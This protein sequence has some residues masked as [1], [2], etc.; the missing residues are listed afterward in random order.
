MATLVLPLVTR[1]STHALPKPEALNATLER[2]RSRGGSESIAHPPETI[3]VLLSVFMARP[4]CCMG[5]GG[6][7]GS[8]TRGHL[9]P[10]QV[11]CDCPRH[12]S[13]G[14][15]TDCLVIRDMCQECTNTKYIVQ[16][17]VSTLLHHTN[18]VVRERASGRKRRIAPPDRSRRVSAPSHNDETSPIFGRQRGQRNHVPR[19]GTT[20]SAST[21]LGP[22]LTRCLRSWEACTTILPRLYC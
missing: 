5:Y 10:G 6:V 17:R 9:G 8:M 12:V 20:G 7:K 3:K 14:P 11:A 22:E 16:L 19:S 13:G 21:Q 15:C 18:I 4:A 2:S 1:F